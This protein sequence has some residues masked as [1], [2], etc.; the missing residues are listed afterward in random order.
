MQDDMS[1]KRVAPKKST[2]P[3]NYSYLA[4]D[5]SGL[6]IAF[7]APC[8]DDALGICRQEGWLYV[9]WRDEDDDSD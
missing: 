2:V 3:K 4:R 6:I 7:E 8:H 9:G 1:A 5:K